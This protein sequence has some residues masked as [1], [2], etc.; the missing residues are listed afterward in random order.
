MNILRPL[1]EGFHDLQQINSDAQHESS[2]NN[3]FYKLRVKSN[4]SGVFKLNIVSNE[5]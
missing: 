3:L 5:R 4:A 2:E 1:S